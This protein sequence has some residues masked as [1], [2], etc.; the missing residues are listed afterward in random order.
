MFMAKV[1]FG[2]KTKIF[3][4]HMH[5]DHVLGLPGLFQTMSLLGREEPLEIFGPEG[6]REFIEA[7][8]RTVQFGLTFPIIA[9]EAK[10]ASPLCQTRDYSIRCV[11]AEHSVPAFSYGFFEKERP[12]KFY[13]EKAVALGIPKGPK[14]SQLQYNEPIVLEGGRIVTP[15][16]VAGPRRPG[17]KIVY[18]GDTR[19]SKRLLKFCYGADLL[20]HDST[21]GDDLQ[22]KAFEEGHSTASQAARLAKES[23]VGLLALFHISARYVDPK[24]LLNEA[25]K[26]FANV[27]VA[28]D[29]MTLD[30]PYKKT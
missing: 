23:K 7:L 8:K 19:P 13:P 22:E 25:K 4:T 28:E 27:L 17:R 18:S 10:E 20:V 29:F 12:G 1:G 6:L 16:E 11:E 24:I 3:I 14:W 2:R 5:G 26:I 9:E 30:I 15:G 21:F